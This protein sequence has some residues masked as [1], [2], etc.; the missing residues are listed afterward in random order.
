ML[1]CILSG[2][3]C[4]QVLMMDRSPPRYRLPDHPS[5]P[6]EVE[7]VERGN[8]GEFFAHPIEP[9]IAQD[10]QRIGQRGA[11]NQGA[12]REPFD[13][14]A[15]AGAVEQEHLGAEPLP[16]FHQ[17]GPVIA[18]WV[19]DRQRVVIDNVIARIARPVTPVH[20]LSLIHI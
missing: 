15:N 11:C 18:G 9:P 10:F 16:F 1:Q 20:I 19:R 7:P 4:A 2:G 12:A 6:G 13:P 3:C 14:G 5:C 17:S 8:G